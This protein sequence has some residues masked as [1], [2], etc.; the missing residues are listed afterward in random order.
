MNGDKRKREGR[1]RE[2]RRMGRGK[3]KAIGERDIAGESKNDTESSEEN[4]IKGSDDKDKDVA[5]KEVGEKSH[6]DRFINGYRD[7]IMI[8][9]DRD[10]YNNNDIDNNKGT[11]IY[12]GIQTNEH[13]GVNKRQKTTEYRQLYI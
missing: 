3:G 1:K 12:P 10:A 6:M 4:S 8:K 9:S 13:V 11:M 5:D 2:Q 7:M